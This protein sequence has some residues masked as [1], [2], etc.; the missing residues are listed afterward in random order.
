M[1]PTG[2]VCGTTMPALDLQWRFCIRG[3]IWFTGKDFCKREVSNML[4]FYLSCLFCRIN[5]SFGT[6][7]KFY[8]ILYESNSDEWL[9]CCYT[10]HLLA[11]YRYNDVSYFEPIWRFDET[12]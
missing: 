3:L 6:D 1:G 10:I 12:N 2:L 7:M 9:K 5:G 4:V 8:K 11:N